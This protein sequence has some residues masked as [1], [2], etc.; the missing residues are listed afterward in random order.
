MSNRLKTAAKIYSMFLTLAK[1][2]VAII[3]LLAV[4]SIA[5]ED[6][7][8]VRVGTPF[9]EFQGSKLII[10]VPITIKNYG[11]YNI[12]HLSVKY[13]ISNESTALLNGKSLIG[14]IPTSSINTFDVPITIDFQKLYSKEYPQLYHFFNNDTLKA[15]ITISLGYMLNLTDITINLNHT[16]EW[17]PPIESTEV[18]PL[19]N[20][21]MNST[22]YLTFEIPYHIKTANYLSGTAKAWGKIKG[23]DKTYGNFSAT[24][25]LGEDYNGNIKVKVNPQDARYIITH[26]LD[27]NL[28]GNMSIFGFT[29]PLQYK[30]FWGAPLDN[31]SYYV[32]DNGAVYYSFANHANYPIS[33]N[34][35]KIYYYQN[36]EIKRET[37]FIYASPGSQIDEYEEVNITQPVNRVKIIFYE[38]YTGITYEVVINL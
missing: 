18:Y 36:Q 2:A 8:V 37:S 24:I 34:I 20:V 29:I 7:K 21:K 12:S 31:L 14:N 5:V 35:T 19:K 17:K 1:I 32:Y 38:I 11:F 4:Y 3:I 16:F 33:L 22:R 9:L 13:T 23:Q 25:T 6:V 15:N 26:S 30:Y 28:I 27:M 10:N